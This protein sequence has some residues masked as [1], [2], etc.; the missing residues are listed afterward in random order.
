MQTPGLALSELEL[1]QYA[2]DGVLRLAGAVAPESV[3]LLAAEVWRRLRIGHGIYPDRPDTWRAPHPAQLGAN[4]DKLAA[5]ASPRL[6]AVFDT[7]LGPGEWIEPSRWGLPMVTLPGFT[8]E[9]IL[10]HKGWHLDN[11]AVASPPPSVRVF[12]LLADLEPGGGGT[13]FI[14]GSHRILR[15]LAE[16]LGRPLRANEA[17]GLLAERSAWFKALFTRSEGANRR[18]QFM[19]QAQEA[20][21]VPVQVGEMTG[22][23]GDAYLMDPLLLHATLPNASAR[24]RLMVMDWVRA[25][26]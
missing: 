6:R 2:R 21:G 23:A 3:S 24:P 11:Q 25:R 7:I 26:A 9:W 10:P 4:D 5:M 16:E 22:R 17:R 18:P 19:Q 1:A 13:G 15:A 12:V 8:R 14:A 20:A